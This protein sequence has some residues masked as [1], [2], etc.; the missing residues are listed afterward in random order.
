MSQ[1]Q[2]AEWVHWVGQKGKAG[3]SPLLAEEKLPHLSWA[4]LD[5][6]S[7]EDEFSMHYRCQLMLWGMFLL[8]S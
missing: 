3:F 6:F 7:G 5:E 1:T 2:H 4:L 8:V